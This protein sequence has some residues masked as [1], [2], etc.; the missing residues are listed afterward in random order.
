[1]VGLEPGQPRIETKGTY[2]SYS[3]LKLRPVDPDWVELRLVRVGM[4]LFALS[5]TDPAG[6]WQLRDRFYRMEPSPF[7]QVGLIAYTTSPESKPAPENAAVSNRSIDRALPVDML[8]DVDWIRY[9]RPKF[10]VEKD[11]R[12]QVQAHPL[13]DPNLAEQDILAA[14]GA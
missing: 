11:W 7:M 4:T 12:V 9:S 3:S 6:P 1:G 8:M 2:N 10:T 14:L 5:R 13:A